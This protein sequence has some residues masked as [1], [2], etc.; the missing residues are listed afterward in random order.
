[1]GSQPEGHYGELADELCQ[2]GLTR[3]QSETYIAL[4]RSSWSSALEVAK[5]TG[6]HHEEIYRS[7]DKLSELG[8][9]S[10]M[11]GRPTRYLALPPEQGLALLIELETQKVQDL[12]DKQIE[13]AKKLESIR[14]EHKTLPEQK[15]F[16]WIAE[17]TL[18]VSTFLSAIKEARFKIALTLTAREL[19]MVSSGNV[20][21]A[22]LEAQKRNVEIEILTRVTANNRELV[23]NLSRQFTVRHRGMIPAGLALFDQNS[24][25]LVFQSGEQDDQGPNLIEIWSRNKR[26]VDCVISLN[27]EL[28]ES[29]MDISL[30]FELIEA[31]S[32]VPHIDLFKDKHSIM[33]VIAKI[34]NEA[35]KDIYVVADSKHLKEVLLILESSGSVFSKKV[36]VKVLTQ[37]DGESAPLI[38]RYSSNGS[39]AFRYS[40]NAKMVAVSSGSRCII[41]PEPSLLNEGIYVATGVRASTIGTLL[42]DLYDAA[43]LKVEAKS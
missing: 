34:A 8:L 17:N 40:E 2:Y 4:T 28:W 3:N 24:A 38:S 29:A 11:P 36:K 7:I 23:Q 41:L 37:A 20:F 12:K 25:R 26:F 9:I 14:I 6:K 30:I 42:K 31:G 21:R 32:N 1:M 27:S 33:D 18:S 10:V 35:T 22:L 39:F 43:P 13:L 19:E 15:G 16:K 5:L